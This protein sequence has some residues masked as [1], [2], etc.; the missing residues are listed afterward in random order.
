MLDPLVERDN[1]YKEKYMQIARKQID[2][3]PLLT[4]Q[5]EINQYTPIS[6]ERTLNATVKIQPEEENE[7]DSDIFMVEDLRST[8]MEEEQDDKSILHNNLMMMEETEE[9]II[10]DD[11]SSK[12]KKMGIQN[13]IDQLTLLMSTIPEDTFETVVQ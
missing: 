9:I 3:K 6:I 8:T 5:T 12:D 7:E 11:V 1:P 10:D 4:R 13:L 2:W